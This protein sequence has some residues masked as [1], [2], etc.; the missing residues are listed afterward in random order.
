MQT[1]AEH[2]FDVYNRGAAEEGDMADNLLSYRLKQ[3]ED[4][5]AKLVEKVQDIDRWQREKDA[6]MSLGFR[7]VAVV[8]AVV[9]G[10]ASHF[11][12]LFAR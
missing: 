12:G 10:A 9:G 4:T 8:S 2:P 3:L 6:K 11:L 5:M 1:L 7:L